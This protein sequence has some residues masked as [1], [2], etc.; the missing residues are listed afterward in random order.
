M[1]SL[2]QRLFG[3]RRKTPITY[4]EARDIAGEG[5]TATRVELASRPDVTPEILYYL[6]EDRDAEVRRAV[7]VNPVTPPQADLKLADDTDDTVRQGVAEKM[8]HL[9]PGLGEAEM[10]RLHRSAHDALERLARDEMVRVRATIADALKDLEYAPP[11]VIRL[12]ARDDAIEVSVPI[13][14][15]SPVLTDQDLLDIIEGS[16]ATARLAAISRRDQVSDGV[17]D[18]IVASDDID[19]ISDLL[20]NASAQIREETLDQLIDKAPSIESWHAP[21]VRRPKLSPLAARRLTSFV[22]KG[23]I[24]VLRKRKDLPPEAVAA[25]AEA[26]KERL[27]VEPEE[28]LPELVEKV[29]PDAPAVDEEVAAREAAMLR[30]QQANRNK[31]LNENMIYNALGDDDAAFVVCA[32]SLRAGVPIEVID[33]VID[34][35]SPEGMT[36]LT[37]KAGMTMRIG[38][39]LQQYLAMVPTVKVLHE[40]DEDYP[41]SEAEITAALAEFSKPA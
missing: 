8:S 20:G 18:A 21:L 33:R 10:E 31:Q 14:E 11:E 15:L 9:F 22:A 27:D 25:V 28:A 13:L 5:D 3:K 4:E 30:V 36:A 2:L 29:Q 40:G 26:V 6:S 32:L 41:L 37:W 17:A 23:L 35:R 7:A 16:P 34:A 12:L 38:V 39:K 24:D 19:A 1:A